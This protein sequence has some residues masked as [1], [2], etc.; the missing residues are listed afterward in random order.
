MWVARF[1]NE[2]IERVPMRRRWE[3]EQDAWD[4]KLRKPREGVVV[5]EELR[6]DTASD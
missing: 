4:W 2:P 5:I 1:E 6:D 3:R